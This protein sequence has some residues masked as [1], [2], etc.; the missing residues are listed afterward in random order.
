LST[1]TLD[2]IF[3]L[4]LFNTYKQMTRIEASPPKAEWL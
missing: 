3:E 1:A 4:A 2:E